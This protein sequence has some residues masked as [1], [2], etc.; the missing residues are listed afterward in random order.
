VSSRRRRALCPPSPSELPPVR[1]AADRLRSH[2]PRSRVRELLATIFRHRVEGVASL[3]FSS[4]RRPLVDRFR[5]SYPTS[6][7]ATLSNR[8]T[9]PSWPHHVTTPAPSPS[10]LDNTASTRPLFPSC[11]RLN[12][13]LRR[14]STVS[15]LRRL[16][17][18]PVVVTR[19]EQSRQS[20]HSCSSS[21]SHCP[22]SA[23]SPESHRLLARSH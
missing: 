11:H 7:P 19:A 4:S 12:K 2:L 5:L 15:L 13:T 8:Y 20:R 9:T 10:L 6:L 16:P 14:L 23:D 18:A 3:V 21:R 1:A 22:L 17:H